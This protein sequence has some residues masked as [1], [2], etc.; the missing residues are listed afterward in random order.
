MRLQKVLSNYLRFFYIFGLTEYPFAEPTKTKSSKT[1]FHRHINQLPSFAFL[2]FL[3]TLAMFAV[4]LLYIVPA[5]ST[6]YLNGN[7]SFLLSVVYAL[8][9]ITSNVLSVTLRLWHCTHPRRL[10][11]RLVRLDEKMAKLLSTTPIDG[12]RLRAKINFNFAIM[13]ASAL[14]SF[15][16]FLLMVFLGSADY[17]FGF[18]FFTMQWFSILLQLHIA[19][20]TITIHFILESLHDQID[21]KCG[22]RASD[23]RGVQ[24]IYFELWRI[25]KMVNHDFGWDLAS[26]LSLQVID[27]IYDVFWMFKVLHTE[28]KLTELIRKIHMIF[29]GFN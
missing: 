19:L 22:V 16:I 20:Y 27:L 15:S 24:L 2:I 13:I 18:Y 10:V 11:Q 23:M 25:V 21:I 28:A 3:I 14:Q 17:A 7:I 1:I 9:I 6:I 29:F 8:T 4:Y 5:A 26:V 12:D